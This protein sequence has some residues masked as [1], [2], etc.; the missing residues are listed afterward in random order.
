MVSLEHAKKHKIDILH[1]F[2]NFFLRKKY[3]NGFRSFALTWQQ[4]RK[5]PMMTFTSSCS[6]F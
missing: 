2:L 3:S 1:R 6:Q 5:V 4:G